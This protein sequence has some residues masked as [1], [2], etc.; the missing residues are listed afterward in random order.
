[1]VIKMKSGETLTFDNKLAVATI[2]PDKNKIRVDERE[3]RDLIFWAQL[4][5]VEYWLLDEKLRRK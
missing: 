2:F 1:M 4:E 3:S 5:D